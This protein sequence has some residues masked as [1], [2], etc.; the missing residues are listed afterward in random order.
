MVY[1]LVPR[2]GTIVLRAHL[3]TR[4]APTVLPHTFARHASITQAIEAGKR[5]GNSNRNSNRLP[6][7]RPKPVRQ[8]GPSR[9]ELRRAKFGVPPHMDRTVPPGK[10]RDKRPFA[11][12]FGE[13]PGTNDGLRSAVGR[14]GEARPAEEKAEGEIMGGFMKK[15][16][17]KSNAPWERR[18]SQ[19]TAPF[20]G[21]GDRWMGRGSRSS[22]FGRV[23]SAGD[24]DDALPSRRPDGDE[25]IEHLSKTVE[26]RKRSQFA[27]RNKLT[28]EGE[29]KSSPTKGKYA[30]QRQLYEEKQTEDGQRG[31][32]QPYTPRKISGGEGR[33]KRRP[34]QKDDSGGGIRDQGRRPY[35]SR[36]AGGGE[37]GMERR[38]YGRESFPL[39]TAASEFIYGHSSVLAAMKANRRKL[40]TLWVHSQRGDRDNFMAKV[41]AHKMFGIVR[42]VGD[43]FLRAMDKVSSGRPHNGIV[44]ETSP[45]PVPPIIALK[46]PSIENQSFGVVLDSQSAEDALVNGKNE[47]YTYKSGGW[48]HPLILYVDGVVGHISLCTTP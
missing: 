15:G 36:I 26:D 25:E 7:S 42:E 22:R 24:G 12:R 18:G 30:M 43:D 13:E 47:D 16:T 23:E 3:R 21:E 38:P 39:T 10:G 2:N 45:L 48:R 4:P 20:E 19:S 11:K 46:T 44:M 5:R 6:N 37:K 41:R 28:K 17:W 29:L 40:Y 1:A 27:Y 14:L 31:D 33:L 34:Y 8:D 9:F 32:R 35:D